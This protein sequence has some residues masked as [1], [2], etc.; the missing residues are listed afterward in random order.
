MLGECINSIF[1]TRPYVPNLDRA[2]SGC[3]CE[4]ILVALLESNT[5]DGS[6][7]TRKDSAL[8]LV[9]IPDVELSILRACKNVL[10]FD[11]EGNLADIRG[12]AGECLPCEL[13]HLQV[14]AAGE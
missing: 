8:L 4:N 2:V 6:S 1:V 13:G 5:R 9:D 7:V 3:G 10:R 12:V 11:V 14:G